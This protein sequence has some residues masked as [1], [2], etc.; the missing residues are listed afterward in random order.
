MIHTA[1][2]HKIANFSRH[3]C[4]SC[5]KIRNNRKDDRKR[6][7]E[8]ANHS[9]KV[10][11]TCTILATVR[12]MPYSIKKK[13]KCHL[14]W[15]EVSPGS[16]HLKTLWIPWNCWSIAQDIKKRKRFNL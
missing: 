5:T 1:Y 11:S 16:F 13:R 14:S 3:P 15:N 6:S 4:K 9:R 7:P 10:R 12:Y 2:E 8:D